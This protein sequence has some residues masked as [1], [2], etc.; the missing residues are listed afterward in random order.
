META[1]Q[2]IDYLYGR[3]L[4]VGFMSLRYAID[5]GDLAWANA[6]VEMLHNIPSLIGE[7]NWKRHDY[8]MEQE[9]MAYVE[10]VSAPGRETAK[11]RMETFYV[12]F[13]SEL[14]VLVKNRIEQMPSPPRD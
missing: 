6:E 9:R 5:T 14:G 12:P 4:T 8:Y 11:S 13:W 1:L 7:R 10:W 3:L 2:Q